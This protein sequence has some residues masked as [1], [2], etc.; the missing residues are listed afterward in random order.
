M[1]D[2][3]ELMAEDGGRRPEVGSEFSLMKY[4]NRLFY[5]NRERE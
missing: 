2:G 1:A 4:R 3:G 5:I